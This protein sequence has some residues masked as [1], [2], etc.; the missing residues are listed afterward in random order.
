M[1]QLV[2]SDDKKQLQYHTMLFVSFSLCTFFLNAQTSDTLFP[3]W[4][5]EYKGILDKEKK[6]IN[7]PVK[8]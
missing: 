2:N 6:T 5:K 7:L 3:R 8:H 1:K 4:Q